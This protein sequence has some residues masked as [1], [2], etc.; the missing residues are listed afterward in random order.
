MF[1]FFDE[2]KSKAK[3]LKNKISPYQF[4]VI[5]N[6]LLYAEGFTSIITYTTELVAFKVKGGVVS[7]G[8]KQIAIRE[9]TQST[10]TIEGEISQVELI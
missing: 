7:V 3:S 8:G 9:M 6:S 5:G 10:I 2:I 4:V 1:N